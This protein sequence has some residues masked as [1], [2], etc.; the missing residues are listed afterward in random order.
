MQPEQVFD[1]EPNVSSP[2]GRKLSLYSTDAA[3]LTVR[4]FLVV[5]VLL[6]RLSDVVSGLETGPSHGM[7]SDA[8]FWR[9]L[10]G[11]FFGDAP[12]VSFSLRPVFSHL[13]VLETVPSD[14]PGT[15]RL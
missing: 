11:E 9:R 12:C 5:G 8:G 2:I 10:G 7:E 1:R 6:H 15:F 13:T 4:F 3:A 14:G